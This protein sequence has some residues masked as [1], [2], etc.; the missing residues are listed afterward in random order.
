MGSLSDLFITAP[1]PT[2]D[3]LAEADPDMLFADGFD[4]ALVGYAEMYGR[5]LLAAYDRLKCIDILMTRDGM[6]YDGAVEFFE[7]N[8]LGGWVGEYTPIFL[9]LGTDLH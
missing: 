3:Q 8:V 1:R 7:F 6:T 9:T 4:D 5:P 2:R